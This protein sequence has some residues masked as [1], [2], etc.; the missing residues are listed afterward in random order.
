M[1]FSLFLATLSVGITQELEANDSSSVDIAQEK[2]NQQ[3][4]PVNITLKNGVS[5]SGTLPFNDVL[6]W[7]P[8]GERVAG[9]AAGCAY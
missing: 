8:D 2:T 1:L 5:I 6:L 4:L 9:C 3:L 7:S